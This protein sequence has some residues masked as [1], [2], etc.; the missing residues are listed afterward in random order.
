MIKAVIENR[1]SVLNGLAEHPDICELPISELDDADVLITWSDVEGKQRARVARC[2][3]IGIPSVLV[4]HGYRATCAYC[5]PFNWCKMIADYIFV[6]GSGDKEH[7]ISAGYD[8]DKIIVT[9]SI[10]YELIRGFEKKKSEKPTVLFLPVKMPFRNLE[11]EEDKEFLESLLKCGKYNVITKFISYADRGGFAELHDKYG[12]EYVVTDSE[13]DGIEH[14][15]TV[16]RLLE[17]S[18]LAVSSYEGTPM[19]MAFCM[20][21]PC[22]YYDIPRIRHNPPGNPIWLDFFGTGEVAINMG[23]IMPLVEQTLSGEDKYAEARLDAVKTRTSFF[24]PASAI[25]SMVAA[26]KEIVENKKQGSE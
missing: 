9:G 12:G 5:A 15:K 21:I 10:V 20:D 4:Q 2:A 6:W 25:E 7:M 13:A 16:I 24:E 11:F 17:R 14:H 19:S 3:E 1:N 23:D 8:P 18:D 26:V 22:L